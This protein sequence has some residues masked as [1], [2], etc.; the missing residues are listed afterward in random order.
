[1]EAK[2]KQKQTNKFKKTKLKGLW[3]EKCHLL[4]TS[5]MLV[6][7]SGWDVFITGNCYANQKK[8]MW[9]MRP[10]SGWECV[11]ERW[12]VQLTRSQAV[13]RQPLFQSLDYELLWE[14]HE[15]HKSFPKKSRNTLQ[16]A[17]LSFDRPR[18]KIP[19]E[20]DY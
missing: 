14:L 1:M 2:T 10:S 17:V 16:S 3:A 19:G 11:L 5:S 15:S 13:P 9:L 7:K 4:G 6:V 18:L 20:I 12:S 8:G